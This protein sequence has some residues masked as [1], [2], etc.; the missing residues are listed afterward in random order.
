MSF[1][2]E[3]ILKSTHFD[4]QLHEPCSWWNALYISFFIVFI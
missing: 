1:F 4:F 2:R 3:E